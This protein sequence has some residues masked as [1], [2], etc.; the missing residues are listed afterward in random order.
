M[1]GSGVKESMKSF[2]TKTRLDKEIYN[3]LMKNFNYRIN[4]DEARVISEK[5]NIPL[6]PKFTFHWKTIDKEMLTNLVKWMEKGSV[7]G[8]K[9]ILPFNYDIKKDIEEKDSKWTGKGNFI[10]GDFEKFTNFLSLFFSGSKYIN[11]EGDE[12]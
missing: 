12:K 9:I 1:V 11:K 2:E 5:L 7:K 3:N 6:H 10:L 8:D 4:F